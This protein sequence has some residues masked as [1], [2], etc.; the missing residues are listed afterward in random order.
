MPVLRNA[1][2]FLSVDWKKT[3]TWQ[4]YR[5]AVSLEFELKIIKNS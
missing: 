4:L 5:G 1:W 3:A 2:K